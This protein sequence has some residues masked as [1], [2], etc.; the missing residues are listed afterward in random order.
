MPSIRRIFRSLLAR[1]TVSVEPTVIVWWGIVPWGA[2]LGDLRAVEHLSAALQKQGVSH[3]IISHP[4]YGFPGHVPVSDLSTIRRTIETMVFVCGPIV[5][6]GKLKMFF[7]E[8]RRAR[9]FAAGVSV[10]DNHASMAG[11]FDRI[12]ARDGMLPSY[13]DL[14]ITETTAPLD[15]APNRPPRIGLC[16]R[17]KQRDYGQGAA[18]FELAEQLLRKTA[19]DL[20]GTVVEIDTV[21]RS[22]NTADQIEEQIRSIDLMLT[23]RLH[24][25]LFSLAFGKPVIAVDQVNGTAKVKRVLDRL[26]WPFVFST[27]SVTQEEITAA[28]RSMVASW[29]AE[30][31]RFSQRRAAQLSAEAVAATVEMMRSGKR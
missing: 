24:G 27:D 20:G 23:T 30:Q 29:P 18:R 4:D 5:S 19:E 25:S 15:R 17:G 28:A 16:L 10:L 26:D 12:I 1:R 22:G 31:V 14:A 2:T 21:I 9:K 7:L 13:F 11:K 3:S 8:H 6:S